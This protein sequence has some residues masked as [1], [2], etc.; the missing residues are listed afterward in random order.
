[1]IEKIK[2]WWG[3]LRPDLR[4]HVTAGAAISL[5]GASIGLTLFNLV[6]AMHIMPWWMTAGVSALF[7]AALG[8]VVGWF[9]EYEY[10]E[11][12]DKDDFLYTS[13]AAIIAAIVWF[14]VVLLLG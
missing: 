8:S 2:A 13:R 12:P 14:V 10:D 9:K 4:L 11:V 7:G 5:G 1:M 6:G 3:A